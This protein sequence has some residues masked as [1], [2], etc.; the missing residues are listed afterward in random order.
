[1][2][3]TTMIRIT[4]ETKKALKVAAAEAG[5]TYDEMIRKLLQYAANL[6]A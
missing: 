4:V 1:M 3:D 5:L 2:A 6:E